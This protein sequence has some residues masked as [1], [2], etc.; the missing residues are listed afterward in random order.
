[1]QTLSTI[2]D[3]IRW[4]ASQFNEAQLFF[5]H[6]TDNAIDEAVVLVLYALRLPLDTPNGFWQMRLTTREKQGVFDLLQQRI[7]Q[8]IPAPYLTCEA[9]FANLRFYVD[10]RVIIPRS[11]LAELI[12]RHFAPWIEVEQVK[13]MLDL[14]T[15]SGC[16]AIASALLAFPEADVDAVDIS[17]DA[18]VVAQ[19]NITYYGLEQRVHLVQSDLFSNLTGQQYDLIVCNPPYADAEEWRIMPDEYRHEPPNSLAGGEDGLDFVKRIL[20]EAYH[21]LTPDGMLIMEVGTSQAAL[22]KQYPNVTFTW[23]EFERG[24]EGVFL[25]VSEQLQRL[26]KMS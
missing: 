15:G 12:E 3:F 6:G 16:I 17:A 11:P 21:H 10:T 23:L 26:V 19:Q 24:G 9:W 7:Q 5:G 1:M 22:I 20:K 2:G 25:L 13:R 8:R 14:C 4:G 18:L